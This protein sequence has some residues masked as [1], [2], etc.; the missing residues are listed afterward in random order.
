MTAEISSVKTVVATK[1]AQ[2]KSGLFGRLLEKAGSWIKPKGE[3]I[4]N[5]TKLNGKP[6]WEEAKKI[7]L[8]ELEKLP[9][10]FK[11][12]KALE[13]IRL[14]YDAD[15]KGGIAQDKALLESL[16][17]RTVKVQ[18]TISTQQIFN[19]LQN[20]PEKLS[21]EMAHLIA[22]NRDVSKGLSD[23]ALFSA[24]KRLDRKFG[25]EK[26]DSIEPEVKN[27]LL[28]RLAKSTNKKIWEQTK[29]LKT[30]LAHSKYADQVNEQESKMTAQEKSK[31]ALDQEVVK[32]KEEIAKPLEAAGMSGVDINRVADVILKQN[33]RFME[34]RIQLGQA[35]RPM[36]TNQ[37]ILSELNN[38]FA[39]IQEP[40]IKD[41]LI[42][43]ALRSL[44][45]LETKFEKTGT[46]AAKNY[47][48]ITKLN[49]GSQERLLYATALMDRNSGIDSSS[50]VVAI[51]KLV[52]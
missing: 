41:S 30:F 28:D 51:K 14:N 36:L 16:S 52:N 38:V 8:S 17:A 45:R 26:L 37:N 33:L 25:S 44:Q 47:N 24:L 43:I 21:P 29:T 9:N 34:K 23:D 11:A 13:E 18:F 15:K 20:E 7:D 46:E 39:S 22:G 10:N 1:E 2:K 31:K 49:E 32:L 27:I 4:T 35:T 40:A 3:A 12:P 5:A 48:R 6:E 19:L 50:K 42:K